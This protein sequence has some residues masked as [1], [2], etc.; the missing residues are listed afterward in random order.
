M[1]HHPGSWSRGARTLALAATTLGA[2]ACIDPNGP[3]SELSVDA[4][5]GALATVPAGYGSLTS[6]YNGVAAPDV[7]TGTMWIGGGREGHGPGRDG[8]MG[9]GIAAAFVGGEG[10]GGGRGHRGPFGG[11]VRCEGTTFEAASGRVTCAPV[12]LRNGL[13]V[14]SSARY[15]D[16]AGTVQQAFDTTTTNSVNIRAAVNGTITFDGAGGGTGGRGGPG[17]RGWGHGRGHGGRLLGDTSTIL[18]ASIVVANT[19]DRTV[20]G[21]AAG[22]TQ[23]TVDGVSG[24]SERTTGTSTRGSFVATRT[25]AD[26]TA[27]LRIPVRA[28]TDTARPYPVA[29]T[30]TRVM[31]ASLAYGSGTPVTLSRREVVTYD[32]SATAKVVITENGVTRNCTRP[33]PHGRLTCS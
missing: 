1:R 7:G 12:T 9:G 29:G 5:A 3:A 27:G 15:L 23:R 16:A 8:L 2:T 20:T 30:V 28:S 14:T 4:L 6:S 26:T 24:G 11:G 17:G 22:S 21:L 10:M 19:S 32:G 33:L 13:T 31:N 18:S 25:V